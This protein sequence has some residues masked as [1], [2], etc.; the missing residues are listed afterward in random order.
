MAIKINYC[1]VIGFQEALD[2]LKTRGWPL[3]GDSCTSDVVDYITGNTA[4]FQFFLGE[5]DL[6]YLMDPENDWCLDSFLSHVYIYADIG[7]T[8]LEERYM[9]GVRTYA[10][11]KKALAKLPRVLHQSLYRNWVDTLPYIRELGVAR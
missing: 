1:K 10:D 8:E 7:M 2:L 4:P 6:K 11:L 3:P 5:E 9:V